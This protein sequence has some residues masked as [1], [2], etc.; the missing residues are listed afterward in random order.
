MDSVPLV[1]LNQRGCCWWNRIEWRD[2]ARSVVVVL[3]KWRIQL[4]QRWWRVILDANIIYVCIFTATTTTTIVR[5]SIIRTFRVPWCPTS[6]L[7]PGSIS[8]RYSKK[9]LSLAFFQ[10]KTRDILPYLPQ[11]LFATRTEI[12]VFE[13]SYSHRY[14]LVY[15]PQQTIQSIE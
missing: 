2:A 9:I 6:R 10:W 14:T 8:Y 1:E 15:I 13:H 4:L 12:P 5:I 7:P 11:N 3:V